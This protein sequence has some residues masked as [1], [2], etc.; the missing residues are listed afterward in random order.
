M[1]KYT[2]F[3]QVEY[4]VYDLTSPSPIASMV[5]DSNNIMYWYCY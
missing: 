3:G 5:A 2:F 1:E 4:S